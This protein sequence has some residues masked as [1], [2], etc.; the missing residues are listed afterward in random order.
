MNGYQQQNQLFLLVINLQKT[1]R[2]NKQPILPGWLYPDSLNNSNHGKGQGFTPLC[3]T[4]IIYRPIIWINLL[5]WVWSVF[6]RQANIY[7]YLQRASCMW[8]PLKYGC[9][10]QSNCL[11]KLIPSCAGSFSES[12]VSM[13]LIQ[14]AREEHISLA[15][16]RV[17][18]LAAWSLGRLGWSVKATLRWF[19][20]EPSAPTPTLHPTHSQ[21]KWDLNWPQR[22][23]IWWQ[24][25][26][27]TLSLP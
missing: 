21:R 9:I 4:R 19:G 5:T 18:T 23:A 8:C 10:F 16:G 17:I 14:A 1:A 26:K 2:A 24:H 22:V 3:T 15:H 20:S 11:W 25:L 27:E 13:V 6:V 7:W 12:V